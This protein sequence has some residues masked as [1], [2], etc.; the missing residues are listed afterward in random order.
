MVQVFKLPF[1]CQ[2]IFL[3]PHADLSDPPAMNAA[4]ATFFYATAAASHLAS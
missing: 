1:D 3:S 2:A 4:R